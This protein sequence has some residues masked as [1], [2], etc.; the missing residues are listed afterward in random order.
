MPSRPFLRI[1]IFAASVMLVLVGC[2]PGRVVP[3]FGGPSA[4]ARLIQSEFDV[5]VNDYV[6]PLD[7]RV[8][9]LATATGMY[10]A[11]ASH[12]GTEAAAHFPY[13]SFAGNTAQV[14]EEIAAQYAAARRTYPQISGQ[15]LAYGAMQQMATSVNDCHT[16]FFTPA[17]FRVQQAELEGKL[18][19]GGIGAALQAR[20]GNTPL[21]DEVFPGLP[22]AKAGL[23]RGDAIVRVDG[24]DVKGLPATKVVDLIRGPVG[25]VVRLDVEREGVGMLRFTITRAKVSP[26]AMEA[27]VLS[28]GGQQ[29][30]YVHLFAFS[31]E[32][33]AELQSAL[34]TFGQRGISSWIIDLRDNGGGTVQAL[35][36]T[37]SLLLPGGPIAIL[38]D[39]Q[40]RQR[41]LDAGGLPY[42]GSHRLVVLVNNGT[43]SASEILAAALQERAG[44]V[45]VGTRTAGC[46]AVGDLHPLANGSAIEYAADRVYTPLQGQLLNGVGV[47]PNVVIPLSLSDL[48]ANRDPQLDAAVSILEG[49]VVASQGTA[50]VEKVGG[51]AAVKFLPTIGGRRL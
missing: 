16:N 1:V 46:V 47:R 44:A 20:P 10:D 31:P 4:E 37:A 14:R 25:S 40:G 17:A 24:Q 26:P 3:R 41:Q 30:G 42:M 29:F 48:A 18:V 38:Q 6:L 43:A 23:H 33:P 9:G 45:V 13:L 22:A 51:A 15:A 8:L 19:F 7:P 39:R 34:E 32:M 11:V 2:A 5:L 21:I 49:H 28:Q 36:N 50:S 12:L 27:Q 35:Q